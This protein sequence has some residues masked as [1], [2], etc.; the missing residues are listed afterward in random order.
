[1][2]YTTWRSLVIDKEDNDCGL[3]HKKGARYQGFVVIHMYGYPDDSKLASFE[4][5][6]YSYK[7]PIFRKDDSSPCHILVNIT[8]FAL[9]QLP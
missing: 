8:I 2:R 9:I 6:G 4:P 5:S 1:M 3:K 7:A